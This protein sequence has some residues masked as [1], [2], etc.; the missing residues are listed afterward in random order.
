MKKQYY[1][2]ILTG[3]ART[4]YTGVTNDID[5]RIFQHRSHSGSVFASRYRIDKLVYLE[6]FG[7]VTQAIAR[8]KQIKSW[9]RAK[10]I[11]LIDETN[12]EWKD[13]AEGR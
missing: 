10:K 6:T 1:V 13:L 4:L 7:E 5:R 2:Y 3:H 9:S 11:R 8:E 12:P